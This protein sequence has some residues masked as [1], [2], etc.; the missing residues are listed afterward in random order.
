MAARLY[1]FRTS[2]YCAK[3]RKILD[4]KGIAYEVIEVDYLER[5]ELL[6]ASG[7]L[8]VPALTLDGGETIVDSARIAL[9]LEEL[10]PEPTILPVSWRGLHLALAEYL[11]NQV[12]ELIFR[13]RLPYSRAY[14]RA[15]GRDREA[16]WRLVR[17]KK[18]G[19][20][21]IDRTIAE[22]DL[23]L[24][25]ACELLAY[26][27]SALEGKAFLLGD[28]A[29][30]FRTIW[31]AQL[32]HFYRPKSD[33]GEVREPPRVLRSDRSNY[34]EAPTGIEAP[35]GRIV[36]RALDASCCRG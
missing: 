9:R 34:L 23:H 26:F 31:P 13:A 24:K 11:D 15:Q 22:H 7:Q 29:R 6:Q 19:A 12:E 5:K 27:D 18:Y 28:R 1:Q 32:V 10:V 33:P 36:G 4:F 16:L 25:H 8:F 21:F 14:F 35:T 17:E 3:V 30:R 2:P 20:G